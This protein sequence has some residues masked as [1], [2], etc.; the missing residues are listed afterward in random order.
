MATSDQWSPDEALDA[1]SVEPWDEALDS[2]DALEPGAE[3][4]PDGER[5]LDRQ[6]FVDDAELEELGARLDDPEQEA[7]LLE[8]AM[9]D[10]D[11]AGGPVRARVALSDLGWDL[12]AA[13]REASEPEG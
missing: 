4:L 12:D 8:G 5:E 11:G 6:L 1:E 9:D 10:P 3:G 7:V 13:E 2:E